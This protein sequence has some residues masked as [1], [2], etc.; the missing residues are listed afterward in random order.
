MLHY[1]KNPWILSKKTDSC[2]EKYPRTIYL[3]I[4]AGVGMT[5]LNSETGILQLSLPPP[6][7]K[8]SENGHLRMQRNDIQNR[9][10]AKL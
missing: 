7:L 2:L 9:C 1:T 6:L 10:F 5:V 4:C 3:L 8:L